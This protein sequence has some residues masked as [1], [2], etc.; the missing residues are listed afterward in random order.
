LKHL[1]NFITFARRLSTACT[2]EIAG[3]WTS[4]YA[5]SRIFLFAAIVGAAG[6]GVT[7]VKT[8]VAMTSAEMKDA[9]AKAGPVAASFW[10]AGKA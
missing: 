2:V 3:V 7:D 9:F 8:T 5:F 6:G 1:K 4:G 10:S